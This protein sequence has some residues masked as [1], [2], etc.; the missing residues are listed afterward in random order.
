[1]DMMNKMGGISSLMG[2][3]PGMGQLKQMVSQKMEDDATQKQIRRMRAIISSMTQKERKN[4]GII[5]GSRK[6]RISKGAGVEVA[7]VNRVLKQHRTMADM[8]KKFGKMDK[9]ALMRGGMQSLMKGGNPF[10]GGF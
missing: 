9:K 3:L 7:D 6:V 1:M 4:P 8:M 10:G 5:N 2:M